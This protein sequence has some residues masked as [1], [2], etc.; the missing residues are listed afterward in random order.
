MLY[1]ERIANPDF[2][3]LMGMVSLSDIAGEQETPKR[4]NN[5]KAEREAFRRLCALVKSCRK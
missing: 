1:E 5:H 3:I 2:S 4:E